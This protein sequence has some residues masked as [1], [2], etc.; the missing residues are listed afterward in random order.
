M[1]N[2]ST[3][4]FKGLQRSAIKAKSG[5]ISA[6]QYRFSGVFPESQK[7]PDGPTGD[8][9]GRVTRLLYISTGPKVWEVLGV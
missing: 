6:S 1:G 3:G 8:L 7:H 9:P 2:K 4:P 5:C